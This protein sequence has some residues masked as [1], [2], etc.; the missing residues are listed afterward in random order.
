MLLPAKW[1]R[2]PSNVCLDV[3]GT[4]RATEKEHKSTRKRKE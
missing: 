1:Q 3:A 2:K 4:R